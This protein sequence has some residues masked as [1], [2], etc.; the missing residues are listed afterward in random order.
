MNSLIF[1]QLIQKL[2]N[3]INFYNNF[4]NKKDQIFINQ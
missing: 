4:E 2:K 1:D 3:E